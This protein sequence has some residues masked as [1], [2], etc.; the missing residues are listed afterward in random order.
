ML[1]FVAMLGGC[2]TPAVK[3]F[4]TDHTAY[5]TPA[6]LNRSLM[7]FSGKTGVF[8]PADVK[9]DI[10]LLSRR[11]YIAIGESAFTSTG[12]QPTKDEVAEQARLVGA[13]IVLISSDYKGTQQSSVAVPI[14]SP[15]QISTT[16]NSGTANANVYGT[17]GSAYGTG[18]YSGTSTTYTPR[19][20]ST[21]VV[22]VTLQTYGYDFI[23]WRKGRPRVFGIQVEPLPDDLRTLLQRN[24]GVIVNAVTD[25]SPCFR[26][27]VLKGDILLRIDDTLVESTEQFTGIVDSF[28]DRDCKLTVLREGKE[29]I[30][31]VK[32]NPLPQPPPS[33]WRATRLWG[34]TSY[35]VTGYLLPARGQRTAQTTHRHAVSSAHARLAPQQCR[36][37]WRRPRDEAREGRG[38]DS[39]RTL[40][41]THSGGSRLFLF[42]HDLPF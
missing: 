27:N 18:S 3:Q 29:L 20:I 1:R 30:I 38:E 39:R 32:T 6:Q 23:D 5:A 42:T 41:T 14:F 34:R 11:G 19:T 26:A 7:P 12:R 4:Y 31:P 25:G 40:L 8:N 22:P 13:D 15:G 16:Y 36:G 35:P 21:T 2:A 28:A 37:A 33:K 9:T 24:T 17:G 10:A